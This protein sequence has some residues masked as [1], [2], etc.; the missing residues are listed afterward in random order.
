MKTAIALRH[1]AFEDL[2]TFEQP[3]VEAVYELRYHDV[4][5]DTWDEDGLDAACLLVVLDGPIGV[6]E[7]KEDPSL[8]D[9]LAFVR[10]RLDGG[11]PTFGVCLGAQVM[12][13]A[14]GASVSATG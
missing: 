10:K 4:G 12:A 14:L 6:Y 11:A 7:T 13:A 2:G 1:V 8:A 3:L 9:E 5:L